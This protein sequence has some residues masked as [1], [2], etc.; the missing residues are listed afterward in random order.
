MAAVIDPH[1]TRAAGRDQPLF[2]VEMQRPVGD[3]EEIGHIGDG[4]R[5]GG[6]IGWR[7]GLR[8]WRRGKGYFR[9]C[10]QRFSEPDNR[11]HD[12]SKWCLIKL[13]RSYS[14]LQVVTG[15]K[16]LRAHRQCRL[17][18]LRDALA[19]PRVLA[20]LAAVFPSFLPWMKS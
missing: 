18:F 5:A 9:H 13:V 3:A 2:L 16:L 19:S 15:S 14:S 11:F 12:D 4:E 7:I 6:K 10:R 8:H 17:T 20:F 1:G